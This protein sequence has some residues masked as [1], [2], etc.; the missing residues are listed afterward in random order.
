MTTNR[1][2]IVSSYTIVKGSMINET[3]TVMATWDF[4]KS[5]K[6]NLDRL[7]SNNFIKAKSN[8][9]LVDVAKVL[10]RRFDPN[11]RDRALALL[12]KSGCDLEEWKPLLLWHLTRDEFLLKDFLMYWLFPT[13]Y[14]S[15]AFFV[16]NDDLNIYLRNLGKRGTTK[17]V[18]SATT[19]NR[20]ANGLLKIA[21]DFGL[22]K[23][24]K[25]RQFVSR[26]LPENSFIYLL[27][28]L[29]DQYKDSKKVI[30]AKEWRMF[31]LCPSD[32]EREL[33]R[34]HQFGRLKYDG[35]GGLAK[36]SLPY[37]NVEEYAGSMSGYADSPL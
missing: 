25:E 6:E 21:E 12:A 7:R 5:K 19:S 32:V 2:C 29:F 20:V 23:G 30:N 10:N 17:C 26:S 33:Q 11:G 34:L 35:A 1:T 18:W 37:N 31:L 13:C 28:A 24:S 22:L 36:L 4:S 8:S 9:W 3:Y 27:H 15:S 14:D 16:Q